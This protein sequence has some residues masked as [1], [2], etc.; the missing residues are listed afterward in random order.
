MPKK[1]ALV[2]ESTGGRSH[3]TL[4]SDFLKLAGCLFLGHSLLVEAKFSI[5][6]G[7]LTLEVLLELL[8]FQKEHSM[9]RG[10]RLILLLLP[11][12]LRPVNEH[13]SLVVKFT[14]FNIWLILHAGDADDYLRLTLACGAE[15]RSAE[16]PHHALVIC[17]A[18]CLAHW[19]FLFLTFQHWIY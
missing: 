18:T 14:L 1:S 17:L 6:N 3:E 13:Y 15:A 11:H 5:L 8:R 19:H 12:I 16:V 9:Y 4:Q 2:G 7:E 10:N